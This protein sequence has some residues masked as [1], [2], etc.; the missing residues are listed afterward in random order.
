MEEQK[1]EDRPKNNRRLIKHYIPMGGCEVETTVYEYNDIKERYY[2]SSIYDNKVLPYCHKCLGLG[3]MEH[4]TGRNE[5]DIEICWVCK[6]SGKSI[7]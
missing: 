5:G 2:C 3:S 6:G 4:N 1:E 7:K